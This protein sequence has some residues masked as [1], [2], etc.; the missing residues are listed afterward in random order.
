MKKTYNLKSIM[1]RAWAIRKESA[2]NIGCKVSDVIF[3]ICLKQAWAE[4]EGQN[5]EINAQ[6]VINEWSAMN[7]GE[8]VK[9]MSAC[10]RK[11][12]K[13]NIRYST[14]DHYLQYSE[15]PAFGC[16][17]PHDFDEFVSETVIRVLDKLGDIEK[18][19]AQNERRAAQGKRPITLVSIVYNA[20]R[21]SIAAIY[22]QDSKHSAAYDYE[23]SDDDGNSASY[24]ETMCDDK[25]QNTEQAAIVKVDVQRFL[26]KRDKMDQEIFKLRQKGYSERDIAKALDNKITNIAVHKRLVK[27]CKAM[28]AEGIA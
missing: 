11:A 2:Q 26:A 13:N 15:V 4:A 9:I 14:E 25:S 6:S 10:V 5:A 7:E 27:M 19:A 16:Y 8:Q 17:G 24:L 18:L 21:A 23:I 22:Y 12:A 1:S 3:G 20:A 28:I